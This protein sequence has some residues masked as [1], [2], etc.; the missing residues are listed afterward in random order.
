MKQRKALLQNVTERIGLPGEPIP[1][2]SVVEITEDKRV[3]VENH[4]GVTEYGSGRICIR[5]SFG[6]IGIYGN[7]L[8]LARMTGGLLLISGDVDTVHLFRRG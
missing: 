4:K 6:E 1:G 8:K 2:L 5:V 3:L 7:C